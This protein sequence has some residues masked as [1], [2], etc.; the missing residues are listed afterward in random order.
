MEKR[1]VEAIVNQGHQE[2]LGDSPASQD[3]KS[4]TVHV[5]RQNFALENEFTY[6]DIVNV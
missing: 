6:D 5:K 1:R 4:A 2:S 3:E